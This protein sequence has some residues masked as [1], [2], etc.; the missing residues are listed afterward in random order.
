MAP[1]DRDRL[2]KL[3]DW[4]T[5]GLP[6][7]SLYLD[8]DGRRYPQASS[9]L[10]RAE[11]AVRTAHAEAHRYEGDAGRSVHQDARRMLRYFQESFERD[12]TRGVVL[13][14]CANA[15][16]W[17]NMHFHKP[18]RDRLVVGPRPYLL[19]VEAMLETAETFAVALVDREKAR[20]LVAS[21]GEIEEVT[22]LFDEVPGRHDQGG[23]AQARLQRHIEDHVQ[24]HLKRVAETLRILQQRRPY[25]HLILAGSE[26]VISE[27]ERELH[28]Y[29]RRSVLGRITV[30]IGASPGE[31]LERI[32][33]LE[34]G[35]ERRREEDA[36][37]RLVHETGS[38][39]GRA[40]AGLRDT[41]SAL[42]A[43]R[44]EILVVSS[45]LAAG[46]VRCT[47][48]GHLDTEGDRC[49]ACGGEMETVSDLV[50]E[51]VAS[52]LRQRSRVETVAGSPEL[53]EVGGIGALLRF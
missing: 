2:R 44:P 41:L 24:R 12:G 8:V 39:T 4:V 45:D 43:G 40:V 52:A 13:F 46:G 20:F 1:P 11:R 50:E 36:V 16:L 14:S 34:E 17:E 38:R 30:A 6:V 18:V 35:L 48:C 23:W 10:S 27:L 9:Y 5:Q 3:A 15:G 31:V 33:A 22:S 32:S 25:D 37:D 26:D 29:V 19:P 21:L 53:A 28:D 42:E 49:P 47:S 7:T 51:A